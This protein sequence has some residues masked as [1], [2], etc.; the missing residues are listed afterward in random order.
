MPYINKKELWKIKKYWFELALEMSGGLDH[1]NF[2]ESAEQL[3][4][5]AVKDNMLNNDIVNKAKGTDNE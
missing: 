2:S 1:S 4:Q 3:W 5:M